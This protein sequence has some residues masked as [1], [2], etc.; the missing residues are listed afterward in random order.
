MWLKTDV[1]AHFVPAALLAAAAEHGVEQGEQGIV[2]SE[3]ER[4]RPIWKVLLDLDGHRRF[5][6]EQGLD[7]MVLSL[8]VDLVG[9]GMEPGRAAGWSRAANRAL[10]GALRGDD[11]FVGFATAP[12][13]D[14]GLAA[15]ILDEAV[16]ELGLRGV[17]IGTQIQ[18]R[19]LDAPEIDVFWRR[20]EALG[21]PILMHPF[22]LEP[23]ERVRRYS[24]QHLVANPFES[25]M[26][27]SELIYGGVIDRFPDLRVIL[28][29]GGG[30]L[31]YQIGRLQ[32]GY[33]AQEQIRAR[34]RQAP[35]DYLRWFSFD[36][37]LSQPEALRYLLDM[38]GPER[39][40]LGSDYPYAFGDLAPLRSLAEA[41]LDGDLQRR[42]A[43]DNPERLLAG[44]RPR[45]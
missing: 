22:D 42:I 16:G 1:H 7:R 44:V 25:M 19:G 21:A 36:T 13:Q 20:A 45:G 15:D 26:V 5:L 38:V 43:V 27:A 18:G 2:V 6:R 34:L 41:D 28:C 9:Y 40:V 30:Y 39:V 32:K 33:L 24:R 17:Q 12:L 37:V 29:H 3:R 8:W 10:A 23:S 14:P 35:R 4:P 11:R 31:P